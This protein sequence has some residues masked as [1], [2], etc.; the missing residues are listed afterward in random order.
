MGWRCWGGGTG[1]VTKV[2]RGQWGQL[3][4][5]GGDHWWGGGLGVE[6]L[7]WWHWGGDKGGMGMMGT[8]ETVVGRWHWG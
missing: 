7:G 3:G 5:W 2:G 6:M 4:H 1:V 8:A